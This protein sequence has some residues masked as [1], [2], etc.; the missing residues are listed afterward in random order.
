[1]LSAFACVSCNVE[2]EK[3]MKHNLANRPRAI[4]G[5]KQ[6]P[7]ASVYEEWFEAFEKQLREILKAEQENHATAIPMQ[8]D[9]IERTEL[10]SHSWGRIQL[11]KQILGESHE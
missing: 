4:S 7:N 8:V 10:L 3:Q 9:S 5:M 2:G 1:M 6:L 11:L